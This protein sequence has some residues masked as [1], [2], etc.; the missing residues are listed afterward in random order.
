MSQ[1]LEP[2]KSTPC[3][4]FHFRLWCD[5][6]EVLDTDAEVACFVVPRFASNYNREERGTRRKELPK[7]KFRIDDGSFNKHDQ[8][9]EKC[10][11][12]WMHHGVTTPLT[13]NIVRSVWQT[14]KATYLLT[15]MPGRRGWGSRTRLILCGPSCTFRAAPT[16]WPVPVNPKCEWNG[17]HHEVKNI[18][19]AGESS[20]WIP[21]VRH[22]D[23]LLNNSSYGWMFAL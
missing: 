14:D 1:L 18:H 22:S 19:R 2:Q 5:D 8:R 15:T 21:A 12:I 6:Q 7:R 13:Q 16:P 17:T 9:T 3:E 4:L 10:T 23:Q 11:H 20:Q